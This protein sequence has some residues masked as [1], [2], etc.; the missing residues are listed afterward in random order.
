MSATEFF[1][2][3]AG[4]HLVSATYSWPDGAVV[5]RLRSSPESGV[6]EDHH[7]YF[8]EVSRLLIPREGQWRE[9][10]GLESVQGPYQLDDKTKHIRFVM[11]N[12]DIIELDYGQLELSRVNDDGIASPAQGHSTLPGLH[13]VS[14][15][16][17][18]LSW[19]DGVAEILVGPLME[20][21]QQSFGASH[22]R[23]RFRGVTRL[24][25][26]RRVPWDTFTADILDVGGPLQLSPTLWHIRIRLQDG[27]VIELDYESAEVER[28]PAPESASSS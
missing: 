12:R 23:L 3:F 26:P 11:R 6:G 21:E 9:L 13:D 10:D 24:L 22:A 20:T 4:A 17:I 8:S 28:A 14:L 18:R 1:R 5:I 7:L 25:C 15:C 16:E 19:S 2:D 27:D